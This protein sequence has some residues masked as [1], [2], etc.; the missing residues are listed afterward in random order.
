MYLTSFPTY[1]I[2]PG[3]P[4]PP[5]PPLPPGPPL[6]HAYSTH[7]NIISGTQRFTLFFL[8]L[9]RSRLPQ[10]GVFQVFSTS[11]TPPTAA[12]RV[13]ILPLHHNTLRPSAPFLSTSLLSHL[14]QHIIT[15][16]SC[17]KLG[18]FPLLIRPFGSLQLTTTT[19]STALILHP[20][21]RLRIA[22]TCS[23]IRTT[24]RKNGWRS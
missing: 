11:H 14:R 18:T 22:S 5:P 15:I 17:Y 9:S 16:P 20:F 24:T 21:S 19:L 6:L 2:Y 7:L 10:T 1:P 4:P 8:T 12:S 3:Q 13:S 23:L